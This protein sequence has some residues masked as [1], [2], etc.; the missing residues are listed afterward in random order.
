MDTLAQ[1]WA[2]VPWL[3]RSWRH[4]APD[5]ALRVQP[6]LID[7]MK[8]Y[9]GV[10][11]SL[12]PG[13]L[14]RYETG[15]LVPPVPVVSALEQIVGLAPGEISSYLPDEKHAAGNR[16]EQWELLG[17]A[18]AAGD[19]PLSGRDWLALA[20]L[21]TSGPPQSPE[22]TALW[23]HLLVSEMSRSIGAGY[24]LR[25]RALEMLAADPV[26]S[27]AVE[28]AVR[29]HLA[30]CGHSVVG[31]ALA[32]LTEV[33]HP[34]GFLLA[35]NTYR[36]VGG[37]AL[38][39]SAYVL[40]LDLRRAGQ[41]PGVWDEVKGVLRDD[42][43]SGAAD[44]RRSALIVAGSL[45]PLRL[46]ELL[47]PLS[48]DQRRLIR[49]SIANSRSKTLSEAEARALKQDC[50]ILAREVARVVTPRRP[51]GLGAWLY[52]LLIDG[53]D[54][55]TAALVIASSPYSHGLS[56]AF[57]GLLP[58]RHDAGS[59]REL[60]KNRHEF[61][62]ASVA[63]GSCQRRDPESLVAA[64]R[65]GSVADKQ[66]LLVPLAHHRAFPGDIDLVTAVRETG[67]AARVVYA[68]GMSGHPG[69]AELDGPDIPSD[70]KRAARWWAAGPDAR[71]MD[72]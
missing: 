66:L 43:T 58:S 17:R 72:G 62:Y 65:D 70:L 56:H 61:P 21:I 53:T 49:S 46:Y 9:P 38:E 16:L 67:S 29:D 54:P 27:G 50:A 33:E 13:T 34:R 52:R 69:L 28:D 10:R 44:R 68:A 59:S 15:Q 3:M 45:Q 14:T 8:A 24:R 36:E 30:A 11:K 41:R 32:A 64:Y 48:G 63:F 12:V 55:F 35:L 6:Q 2:P 1:P 18:D 51:D 31:D 47:M 37:S 26:I 4:A 7:A 22:R 5:P 71:A 42:L 39:A 19:I 60:V 25:I 40:A 57:D 23:A 20:R